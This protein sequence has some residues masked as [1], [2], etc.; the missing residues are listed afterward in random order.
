MNFILDA[1]QV[2]IS[3]V[4]A[5]LLAPYAYFYCKRLGERFTAFLRKCTGDFT[6]RWK[7]MLDDLFGDNNE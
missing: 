1:F 4:I 5:T 3:A 6:R 2:I 7:A